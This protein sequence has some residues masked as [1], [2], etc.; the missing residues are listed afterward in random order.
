MSGYDMGSREPSVDLEAIEA[1]ER[2]AENEAVAYKFALLDLLA[3]PAG[4]FVMW[5][6][7]QRL[8]VYSSSFSTDA[9][10]MAF[11]EGRR[12]AGLELLQEIQLTDGGVSF[13]LMQRE[14]IIRAGVTEDDDGED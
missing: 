3:T 8:G 2:R 7:L 4:R 13:N 10:A 6:Q 9:L 5:R 1:A 12:S 14:A 11:K